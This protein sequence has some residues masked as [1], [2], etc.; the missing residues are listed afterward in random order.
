LTELFGRT[1][2][3]VQTGNDIPREQRRGDGNAERISHVVCLSSAA[4]PSQQIPVS[5]NLPEALPPMRE[6]LALWR[7]FLSDEIE[8]ILRDD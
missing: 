5:T 8:A 4:S 3:E 1:E 2:L 7:A 6:E